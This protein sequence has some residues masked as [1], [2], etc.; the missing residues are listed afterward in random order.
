MIKWELI[1]NFKK[2][3]FSED[4][5]KF[6]DPALIYEVQSI[7]TEHA[8]PIYLSPIQGA[9]ARFD[10]SDTSRHFA[11]NRKSDAID[12]FPEGIPFEFYI[13]LITFQKIGGIGIYI[14]TTGL[15]EKPWVMFHIDLRPRTNYCPFLWIAKKIWVVKKHD[16]VTKYFYPQSDPKHWSILNNEKFFYNKQYG[17]GISY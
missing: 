16:L 11:V 6:A 10:G 4:P 12:I 2:E 9:L 13:R 3:E 14:D 7:R 1:R 8:K 5:D 17:T 15:D